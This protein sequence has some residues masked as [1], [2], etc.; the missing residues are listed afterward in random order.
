MPSLN[1]ACGVHARMHAA[2]DLA[3]GRCMVFNED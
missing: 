1:N 2:R 3:G